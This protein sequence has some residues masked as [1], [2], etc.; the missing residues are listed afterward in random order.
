MGKLFIIPTPIG[1]LEDV[2]YRAVRILGDL[3]LVLAEDTRK[4]RVLFNKY[5][6]KTKLMSYHAFNEHDKYKKYIGLIKQGSNIGLVSDAGTPAISDPGF[7]IIRECIKQNLEVE[8]LPGAT[9]LIPAL[10]QSGISCQ[11]FIFEG[12]LP[13]KKG[14]KKR[15]QLLSEETKTVIIYE[16]PHRILKTL[17]QLLDFLG[18]DRLISVIKEISKIHEATYRGEISEIVNLF[19]DIKPRGEFV[20]VVDGKK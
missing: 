5:N 7:L 17:T 6:I 19:Y 18:E 13:L 14:R 15:M 8:C 20:I 1:N 4:T 12:F 16:S 2:T 11:R 9:A 3:D 10:V